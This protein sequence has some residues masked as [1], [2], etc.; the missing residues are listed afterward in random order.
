RARVTRVEF[1]ECSSRGACRTGSKLRTTLINTAG[2]E[3]E[4]PADCICSPFLAVFSPFRERSS[5]SRFEPVPLGVRGE[6]VG[7]LSG[8]R[9]EHLSTSRGAGEEGPGGLT[10]ASGSSV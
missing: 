10:A 5:K 7:F 1:E 2:R 8:Y 4:L 6:T 3:R 9:K